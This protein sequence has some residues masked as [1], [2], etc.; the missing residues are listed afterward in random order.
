MKEVRGPVACGV[1]WLLTWAYDAVYIG[2]TASIAFLQTVRRVVADQI[3]PSDFSHS[4]E[5][6]KMLEIEMSQSTDDAM[7]TTVEQKLQFLRCYFSVVSTINEHA[8][9]RITEHFRRKRLLT[10]STR[11]NWR[12]TSRTAA[13]VLRCLRQKTRTTS[14]NTPRRAHV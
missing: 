9:T 2:A 7:G 11:L 6:E 1:E 8:Q 13:M 14:T 10:Y 3:G 12:R 5:S 4:K